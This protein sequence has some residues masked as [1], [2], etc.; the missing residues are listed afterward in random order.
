MMIELCILHFQ[1]C[2]NAHKELDDYFSNIKFLDKRF[3]CDLPQL[4]VCD[5][6]QM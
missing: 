6:H 2:Y 4:V 3:N 5:N 1:L